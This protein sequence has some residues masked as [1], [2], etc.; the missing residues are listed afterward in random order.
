MTDSTD[1]LRKVARAVAKDVSKLAA[2]HLP[3]LRRSTRELLEKDLPKMS[4]Q[5]REELPR[6]A[7]V[8]REELPRVAKALGDEVKKRQRR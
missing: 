3:E 8:V 1:E 6:V 7:R 5:V 4:S 2:K